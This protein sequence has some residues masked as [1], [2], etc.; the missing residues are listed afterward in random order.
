M[1]TTD[2]Y[3]ENWGNNL[4]ICVCCFSVCLNGAFVCACYIFYVVFDVMFFVK[5]C[6]SNVNNFT[7]IRPHSRTP[8]L[9]TVDNSNHHMEQKEEENNKLIM[10]VF[11]C[12]IYVFI[13]DF[14]Y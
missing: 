2:R 6:C 14:M 1:E 4:T 5:L 12:F 10:F 3:E 11:S 13:G 7:L 9:S 8:L